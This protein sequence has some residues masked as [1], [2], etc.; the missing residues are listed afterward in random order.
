MEQQTNIVCRTPSIEALIPEHAQIAFDVLTSANKQAYVV[1]G[2]I[3]DAVMGSGAHD[4]DMAT[5]ALWYQTR[6]IFES[7][8]FPTVGTGVKHGTV[9]VL[10]KGH[11]VEITTF[12]SDGTYSD[13]RRPD[14]VRFVRSI[15]EDLARRDYTINALAWNPKDGLV[16]PYGGRDDI[17]QGII[18]A[19]G[20]PGK[21][22][23][24][25]ALRILR[26]VRF[27]SQ[28][29]FSIEDETSQAIHAHVDDID[30]VAVERVSVEYD[31]IVCGKNAV[32]ALRSYVDVVSKV[33]P[34]V[35]RMV[36]FDQRSTWHV[37]D[38][39]EHCLHALD[40]LEKDSSKLVK[41]VT[42]LHD[43]G[44]PQCFTV[45]E[46]GRGHFYGHEEHGARLVRA[47][48]KRLRWRATDIAIAGVLVAQHDHHIEP[49]ERGVRR[50]LARLARAYPGA[51]EYAPKMFEDLL[52]IKRADTLAHAPIC[53]ER[54][55]EE[56]DKVEA[57]YLALEE[58]SRA[59]S[60]RDLS[61]NGGDVIALG[62][63]PGPAVGHI[64]KR[65]LNAVIEGDVRNEREA[66]L[67]FIRGEV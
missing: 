59:F 11:P 35:S 60:I 4:I 28:M 34:A 9:T 62:V 44:K 12:R 36:G 24:E 32:N 23:N 26:G 25:D 18:R 39:W 46:D 41:H 37:Y 22:F 21:R 7:K 49:T 31:S 1:G 50:M 48:F 29:G 64:L 6:E 45:G 42:L 57:T 17:E 52:S 67:D 55:L 16:D 8:G 33:I 51:E 63:A 66:L 54:R 65:A 58:Q 14:R 5:D 43:I 19:V 3:R 27:C 2:F 53:T 20:D 56:I 40:A 13:H 61:V 10:I 38:V 15:E 47:A 30:H